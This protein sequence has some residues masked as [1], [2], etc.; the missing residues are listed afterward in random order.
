M[1]NIAYVLIVIGNLSGP[2]NNVSMQEFSSYDTCMDAK[3]F[4]IEKRYVYYGQTRDFDKRKE[5][6]EKDNELIQCKLK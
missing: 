4:I 5:M 3:Q 6:K 2:A 1:N